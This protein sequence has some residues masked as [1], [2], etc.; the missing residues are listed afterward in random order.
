MPPPPPPNETMTKGIA[1]PL[2][3]MTSKPW[4][5]RQQ[6]QRFWRVEVDPVMV[7]MCVV[8]VVVMLALYALGY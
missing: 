4:P 7:G 6:K 3:P 2:T 5:M 8:F 1:P